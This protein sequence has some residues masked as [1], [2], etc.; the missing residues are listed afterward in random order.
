MNNF[1]VMRFQK[2]QKNSC[3]CIDRHNNNREHLSGRKHSERQNENMTFRKYADK[4]TL[5]I[6]NDKIAEIKKRTGK[7]TPKNRVVVAEFVLTFSPEQTEKIMAQKDEW[8]KSNIEWVK[9]EFESKGAEL[10]RWDLHMDETTP[11]IHAFI[12]TTDEKGMFN[13]TQFFGKKKMLENY[14]T[15]YAEAM[16]PYGLERGIS[17]KETKARHITSWE[18]M[19]QANEQIEQKI[20]LLQEDAA[21]ITAK[22]RELAH[23]EKV[24]DNKIKANKKEIENLFADEK[25]TIAKPQSKEADKLFNDLW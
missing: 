23:T 4:T 18:Y 5:H 16:E 7:T 24:I 8:I 17:K 3:P 25:P 15:T 22:Q 14:Q 9:K 13:G 6:V 19:K 2:Y 11:H 12:L 10:F 20:E 1:C 21:R